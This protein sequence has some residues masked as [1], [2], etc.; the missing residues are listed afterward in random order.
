[1]SE[2]DV[3]RGEL[4]EMTATESSFLRTMLS[5]DFP[6]AKELRVQASS[7]LVSQSCG[8]GCGTLDLHPVGDDVVRSPVSGRPLGVDGDIFDSEGNVR[9][10]VMLFVED[11]LLS[12][13]EVYSYYEPLPMPAPEMVEW[14][15]VAHGYSRPSDRASNAA[16]AL[17]VPER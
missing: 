15:R 13:L 2:G 14:H 4:R 10:G 9:G 17:R 1:M 16:M 12:L 3:R 7:L 6:G 5:F 8:C 11:G